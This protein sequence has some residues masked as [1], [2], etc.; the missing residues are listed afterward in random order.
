LKAAG[1]PHGANRYLWIPAFAAGGWA[2][3]LGTAGAVAI[4]YFLA[5]R[6]GLVLRSQVVVAI[7]WPAAGIATGALIALGPA[8]RLP[9]A[10]AVAF[11]SIASSLTVDRNPWLAMTF[12]V[13]DL[14]DVLLPAWLVQR[15]F[16]AVF[17]LEEVRQVLGLLVASAIGAAVTAAGASIAISFVE[18]GAIPFNVWRLWF[19]S[20]SL[21]LITV[22]P[23]LIGLG[24]AL[25]EPPQLR[26]LIE[27]TIAL[28][29]LAALSVFLISLPQGPW[30]TALPVALAF[31]VLLWIAVRCRPVFAAGAMFVVTLTVVWSTTFNMGHFGD[32]S[33]PLADR[34]IAAQTH[35]LAGALLAL[36]LAALFAERRQNETTLK[37]SNERLQLAFGSAKLGALSLD[38]D[39]GLL[40]C[41]A[42]TAQ[43][44]GHDVPPRT[45]QDGMR[46]VHPDDLAH[47]EAAFAEAKRAGGTWNA[48]YRVIHPPG[49]PHA[50]ETR[51]IWN[52]GSVLCNAQGVPVRS[53]GI[54]RDITSRKE[55]EQALAE[56]DAQLTLAGKMGRVGGFTF[57]IGLGAMQ[58]SPGY[59]AIHGLPE[60]T[61]E[62][63]RADWRTRVHPDDLPRLDANLQRDFDARRNEHDCEY[64]IICS[65]GD[66]RWIEARSFISYDREGAALRIIG[67]N[68]DVTERKKAELALAERNMQLALAGK[69]ALVG[70]Y[71]YEADLERMKVSEGYAAMHGL[72]EGTTETTRGEWR[73]RV[74]PVDLAQTEALRTQILSDRQ[75][76]YN[77]D[78]R[79]FRANGEIRWIEARSF[80]S[81]DSGGNPQRIIGVNIDVTERKQTEALLREGEARYRALYDD[82]P[83]MYFTVDAAGLV[84]SVNQFGAQALGYTVGELV[85]QTVL[86]VIHEEDR[87]TARQQL[88]LCAC[89]PSMVVKGEIR[90]VRRD[91]SVLWVRESARAVRDYAGRTVS[92]IVCEDIT[93][94]KRAETSLKE[95]K[96]RLQEALTAGEVMAFEWDAVTGR[97]QRSDCADD[98]LGSSVGRNFLRQVHPDDLGN[99]IAHICGLSP[100]NPSYALTF[101]FVRPDGRQVWLEETAR[102]EFDSTGRLLRING[103]TRDITERKELEDHKN[104]LI[105]ELDHRVKNVLAIV[106]SV[107]ARTQE[108]SGSMAEF[109]AALDDRIKSMATTHELLSSRRWQGIPLAE[110]VRRELA[111]YATT[112]NTGIDGPD[113]LLSAEASQTLAMV[114]HELAANAAKFGAISVKSGHVCVRWSLMRNGHA[115]S[116]LCIQWQES[117][118]P[119][120]VAP[121]RSGFGTSVVRELIPYELGG[122]VELMHPAEGVRATLEIPAHWLA[123]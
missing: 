110:L 112:N 107:A 105:S 3:A 75:S 93:E 102:G 99:F 29:T 7:F 114:L 73:T 115:E 12:V 14:G 98:I 91:G 90:K 35:V 70:S 65:T 71:V 10:I 9:V 100:D 122:S 54:T 18:P 108:T 25:R 11:A 32:A 51:W 74:H 55:A 76:D 6:L 68:I 119:R 61:S 17:K 94:L 52:E 39:T 85:G 80:V 87:G 2:P 56:R 45:M 44:H 64:R 82:N 19:A 43:I 42:R 36:V 123:E 53:L 24:N 8:A 79:I 118:G 33:I 77:V 103:L 66:M 116:R 120:V 69:A 92:L 31:P 88:A 72:P 1:T 21:G 37:M 57:D 59:A 41:D 50:G 5:A 81:Y 104:T 121:T 111:A 4:A 20:C 58:V 86:K 96:A 40:A 38:L 84:L 89:N 49:H 27:G 46:F 117:G 16:G 28:V 95:S 15:W 78:Y 113:V 63:T 67:V 13:L 83:S 60:G 22:A 106:S 101:R 48:E 109:V 23:L 62:T 34:I 47:V 26:E 30:A 97:S